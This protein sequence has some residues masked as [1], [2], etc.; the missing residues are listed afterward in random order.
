VR[1]ETAP[2][3]DFNVINVAKTATALQRAGVGVNLGAHGQ[4]EGLAAH[5]EMWTAALGGMTSMEA[6]RLGTMNGARYLGMD[7]DIGSLEVN[8]LADLVII[9]GDVLA[10]IRNSDKI[11]HV[12]ANG[13]L[14]EAATMNEVG[15]TPHARKPLYFEGEGNGDV[16][17]KGR[18][19]AIGDED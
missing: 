19:H 6:L 12:M 1:R 10:N 18:A 7:K 3:E 11:T 5:W 17:V 9:D 2:D 15:A 8:K 13:R 4:R 16:P 14:Y